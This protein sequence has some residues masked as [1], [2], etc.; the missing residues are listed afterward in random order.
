MSSARSGAAR[1]GTDFAGAP[2]AP[3]APGGDTP[4]VARPGPPSTCAAARG[5][6]AREARR[7]PSVPRGMAPAPPG[8]PSPTRAR[9]AARGTTQ[10][11]PL[12]AAA[13]QAE[14]LH[15]LRA[16]AAPTPLGRP[17]DALTSPP[18][19]SRPAQRSAPESRGGG[20]GRGRAARHLRSARDTLGN[21]V[22][23]YLFG[24][25]ACGHAP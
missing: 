23:S 11:L 18:A 21:V 4:A 17:A 5:N 12:S 16:G 3:G 8:S 6:A 24:E 22:F 2:G 20:A 7:I 15:P 1:R 9:V 19:R 14:P 25:R 10:R 13:A